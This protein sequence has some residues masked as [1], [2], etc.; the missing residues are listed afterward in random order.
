MKKNQAVLNR[1]Y[2]MRERK[3]FKSIDTESIFYKVIKVIY[4]V[5]FLWYVATPFANSLYWTLF[6]EEFN[7]VR[8]TLFHTILCWI[9]TIGAVAGCV[10][11]MKK[12]HIVGGIL[13]VVFIVS[14]I[15]VFDSYLSTYQRNIDDGYTIIFNKAILHEYIIKVL[16]PALLMLFLCLIICIIYFKEQ[17]SIKR[18]YE[19]VLEALYINNKNKL[20][21]GSEEEWEA[22][23]ESL[24]DEQMENQLDKYHTQ[25]YLK[26]K[27]EKAQKSKE[28]KDE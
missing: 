22:L 15:V 19:K 28:G 11:I 25:Q 26:R 20:A 18:D 27:A 13:N 14:G 21:N 2:K 4:F 12:R 17:L 7:G 3:G 24:D 5:A 1:V 8:T 23:L 16:T 9:L 6:F 10:F